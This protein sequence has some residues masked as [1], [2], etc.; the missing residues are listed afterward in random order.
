MDQANRWYR[1]SAMLHIYIDADAC[2]VKD[3]IYRVARRLGLS[4][5]LVANSWMRTPDA[6]WISLEV[7]D[8]AFDAADDWIVNHV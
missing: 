8:D 1:L 5:T 6:A 2:P 3:E 4:V 7:V